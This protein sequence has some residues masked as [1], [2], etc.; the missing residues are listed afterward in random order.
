MDETTLAL[1]FLAI[2]LLLATS[3]AHRIGNERRDVAFL[4]VA[5]TL[6]GVGTAISVIV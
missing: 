4:G 3:H 1:G 6:F 2:T 5:T